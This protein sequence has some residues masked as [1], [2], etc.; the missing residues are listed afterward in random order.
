MSSLFLREPSLRFLPPSLSLISPWHLPSLVDV[1]LSLKFIFL[2]VMLFY[3]S[4]F[5]SFSFLL[6][7][8]PLNFNEYLLD[9]Y[10]RL[11]N[12]LCSVTKSCPALCDPMDY[13]TPGF[14]V[15]HYLLEFAQTHVHW[16]GDATQPSHPLLSPSPTLSL[17][18]QQRLFLFASSGQSIGPSASASVLPMN[19]QG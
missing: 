6:F 15:L 4:I 3:F 2:P 16:V 11:R 19:I 17:S 9:T 12:V 5:T 8:F 10:F 1:S 14:P 13:S 7:A 18:Q